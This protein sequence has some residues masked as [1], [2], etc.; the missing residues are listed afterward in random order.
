M[1]SKTAAGSTLAISAATPATFDAAGYGALTFTEVGGVEKIGGLGATFAKVEFQ[2]LKGPKD[3]HKGSPDYGSLQPSMALDDADAGQT[4]MRTAADD[5]TS[6]LY[7]FKVTYSDGSKRFF[8]GRVFGFP[9]NVDGA[10]SI[11][12]AAPTVEITTKI[13]KVAAA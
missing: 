4:L 10:D 7:S 5:A 13:V 1:G 9:E 6:T 8:Q 3:K 12:M 2:P 11:I